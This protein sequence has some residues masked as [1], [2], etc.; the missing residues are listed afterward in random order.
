MSIV[1]SLS[2]N[3]DDYYGDEFGEDEFHVRMAKEVP[4]VLHYYIL[5][6]LLFFLWIRLLKYSKSERL[7]VCISQGAGV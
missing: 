6:K 2:Y 3:G 4:P 1:L 5:L 7:I